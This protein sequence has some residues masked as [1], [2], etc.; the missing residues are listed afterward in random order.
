MDQH[1]KKIL[2]VEDEAVYRRVLT[3]K[4]EGEGFTVCAAENGQQG[5][6]LAR[7]E[8]PDLIIL[9]LKMPVMD[10]VEMLK[11]LRADAWGAQVPVMVLTALSDSEHVA[12]VMEGGTFQYFIKTDITIDDLVARIVER[13]ASK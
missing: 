5:M 10:G 9:D 12:D 13:V 3:E 6:D 2:V 7:E 8:K 4:L 11:Q 1:N